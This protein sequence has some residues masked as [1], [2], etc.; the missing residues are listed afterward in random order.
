MCLSQC[1]TG[2]GL[3]VTA[4]GHRPNG[5]RRILLSRRKTM[6]NTLFATLLAFAALLALSAN[7]HAGQ[8]Y[9]AA[10]F[11]EAQKA[12]KTI[13]LHVTAPWCSVCKAQHPILA[14]IQKARPSLVAYDIDF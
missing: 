8:P 13:L 10:A 9:T 6:R 7:A 3:P 4:P 12:G 5:I 2:S 14:N 1:R 11:Q